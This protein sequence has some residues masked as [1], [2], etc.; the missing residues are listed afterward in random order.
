MAKSVGVNKTSMNR[1]MFGWFNIAW[2][3]I[4]LF[5]FYVVII[6]APKQSEKRVE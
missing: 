5:S 1:T 4:S 6:V 3:W 2:L